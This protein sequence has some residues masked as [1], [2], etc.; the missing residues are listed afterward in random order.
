MTTVALQTINSLRRQLTELERHLVSVG[1]HD[2]IEGV[3]HH[4]SALFSLL[5][6]LR[7]EVDKLHMNLR[8]L[9]GEDA[10]VLCHRRLTLDEE[11]ESGICRDCA[12]VRRLEFEE[13]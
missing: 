7:E 11:L 8:L 13:P 2:E 1:V 5:N 6:S 4:F 12:Y 3:F 9:A 10:C